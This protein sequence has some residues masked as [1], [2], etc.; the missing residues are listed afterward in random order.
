MDAT[1]GSRKIVKTLA[2]SRSLTVRRRPDNSC[3]N[4]L[5]QS[6]CVHYPFRQSASSGHRLAPETIDPQ[7]IS[8]RLSCQL[9]AVIFICGPLSLAQWRQNVVPSLSFRVLRTPGPQ[10][11]FLQID[12]SSR[13]A[14]NLPSCSHSLCQAIYIFVAFELRGTLLPI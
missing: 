12:L 2:I 3:L 5:P 11:V 1:L 4:S 7:E 8:S 13:S 9:V 14:R 10:I 6:Q